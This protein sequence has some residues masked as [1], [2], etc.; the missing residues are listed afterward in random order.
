MHDPDAKQDRV[1]TQSW[2]A[3]A[4]AACSTACAGKTFYVDMCFWHGL[5]ASGRNL[6]QAM[7]ALAK[8]H[9]KDDVAWS[10]LAH[11]AMLKAHDMQPRDAVHAAW[12]LAKAGRTEQRELVR[13]LAAEA[14][15]GAAAATSPQHP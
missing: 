3:V 8:L 11:T 14:L 9:H 7:K 2:C 12:A 15:A 5:Q 13:V 4:P 6:A 10:L 1:H